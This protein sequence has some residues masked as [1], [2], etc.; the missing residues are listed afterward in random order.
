MALT[1]SPLSSL[2]DY[3]TDKA[4]LDNL[5]LM[6]ELSSKLTQ[7]QGGTPWFKI[8]QGFLAP[9]RTGSFGESLGGA[10]GAMA[11]YQ[12]KQEAQDIPLAK[13]RLELGQAKLG[14]LNEM[15]ATNILGQALGTDSKTASVKVASNDLNMD[16]MQRLM[17]V[18]PVVARKDPKTGELIKNLYSMNNDMLKNAIE[19][20]KA[21]VPDAE[22]FQKYGKYPN[23]VLSDAG[24]S[25]APKNTP[26]TTTLP[27]IANKPITTIDGRTEDQFIDLLKQQNKGMDPN[28]EA[29][30]RARFKSVLAEE[31]KKSIASTSPTAIP[32]TNLPND[33]EASISS[34]P[35]EAQ[36]KVRAEMLTQDLTA[37]NKFKNSIPDKLESIDEQ[38]RI[39]NEIL[40]T[41]EGNEKA[42]GLLKSNPGLA[43]TVGTWLNEG[44]KVGSWSVRL[45]ISETI[46]A[47]LPSE[48]RQ[49][50]EKIESL[51]NRLAIGSAKTAKGSVSNYEDR[52]YKAVNSTPENTPEYIKYNASKIKLQS[53][54]DRKVLE[55]YDQVSDK[56]LYRDFVMKD[57]T[58]KK[59]RTEFD[60]QLENH[61]KNTLTK[62]GVPIPKSTEPSPSSSSNITHDAIKAEMERRKALKGQQ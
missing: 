31:N 60:N 48:Q 8:A 62:M 51:T 5:K 4:K 59:L 52:M 56:M 42:F 7:R 46:R 12:E 36:N 27:S 49:A 26:A 54:F 3:D 9:T 14:A 21:N 50:I 25:V 1:E 16:E 17:Q 13:M 15:E 33:I 45:P 39:A 53:D 24:I 44:L 41:V 61:A 22:F 6:D 47:S 58:Y 28:V 10:A 40:S 35:P 34:L 57:P 20:R 55:A 37:N 18:Y 43:Q 19:A 29:S 23:Q 30:A 11:D 2:A 32:T 38:R